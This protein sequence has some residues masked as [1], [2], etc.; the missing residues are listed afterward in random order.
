MKCP[1]CGYKW[2][3]PKMVEGGKKSK[4]VLTPEQA[5]KM[6]SKREEK[7]REK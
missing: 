3:N 4:R 5:R 1:K 2:K 6:V 7:R